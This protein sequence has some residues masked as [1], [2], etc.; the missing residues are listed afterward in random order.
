MK[1]MSSDIGDNG[2]SLWELYEKEAAMWHNDLSMIMRYDVSPS[3]TIV[4]PIITLDTA[5]SDPVL[6]FRGEGRAFRAE[7]YSQEVGVMRIR[8]TAE[9]SPMLNW[10]YTNGEEFSIEI[11]LNGDLQGMER[12][13]A[14]ITHIGREYARGETPVVRVAFQVLGRLWAE[15]TI[16]ELNIQV[17][18][19]MEDRHDEG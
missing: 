14:R 8:E 11:S 3:N 1:K 19:F 7:Q 18:G 13:R 15:Q 5:M 17:G 10:L 9:I 16:Q 4:I 6:R 12:I 2:V